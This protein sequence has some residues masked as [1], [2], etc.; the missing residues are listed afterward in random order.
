MSVSTV[1]VNLPVTDLERSKAFYTSLGWSVNPL[2]SDENAACIVISDTIYAML[3]VHPF[4][5]TFTSKEIIDAKTQ[6]QG[7]FALGAESRDEVDDLLA[8]GLAAGGAEP[9]AAQDL[10]FMYSRDL[11]DPDGHIWEILWM[12]PAAAEAGPPAA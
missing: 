7:L 6:V 11:E 10:G 3:L 4:F 2:F 8:K 9:V 1:F 5:S 12:D